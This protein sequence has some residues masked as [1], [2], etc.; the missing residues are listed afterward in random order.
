MTFKSRVGRFSDGQE[1][2]DA[3]HEKARIG[4][5][6]DGQAR[7]VRAEEHVVGR[8]STGQETHEHLPEHRRVGSFGDVEAARP[9]DASGR[10]AGVRAELESI[11]T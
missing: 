8:F 10:E 3:S 11:L 7:A 2:L 1:T 4:R 9:A 5:F 6:S